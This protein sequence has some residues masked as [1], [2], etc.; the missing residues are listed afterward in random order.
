MM[1]LIQNTRNRD[2]AAVPAKLDELIRASGAEDEF[3]GIE[4]LCDGPDPALPFLNAQ[5]AAVTLAPQ[6]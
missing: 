2:G 3:M 1:F 4:K 5:K 6:A